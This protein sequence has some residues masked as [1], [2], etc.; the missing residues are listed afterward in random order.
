MIAV[1]GAVL[2]EA[3]TYP[4]FDELWTVT[5]PKDIAIERVLER[6]A[7]L[8][9]AM[10]KDRLDRQITDEER[11]KYAAF[12]YST[13]DASFEQNQVKILERLAHIKRLT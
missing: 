11:L 12:S 13:A 4:F 8:T 9:E 5:L 10:A 6:D 1:E 2:I 3:K 7:H